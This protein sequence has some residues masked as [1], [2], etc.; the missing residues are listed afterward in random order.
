MSNKLLNKVKSQYNTTSKLLNKV[1]KLS[2]DVVYGKGISDE[3][4]ATQSIRA[5]SNQNLANKLTKNLSLFKT[6]IA[7]KQLNTY[8]LCNP[9][10]F[11]ANKLFPLDSVVGGKLQQIAG[12]IKEIQAAL[13]G[14][15]IIPGTIEVEAISENGQEIKTGNIVLSLKRPSDQP[16]ANG[17]TVFIT[18]I[19]DS[20]I[21]VQMTG[22]V[23]SSLVPLEVNQI[24]EETYDAV[25]NITSFSPLEPPYAVNKNGIVL[26]DEEG[27]P[28]LRKFT[29]FKLEIQKT[30]TSDIRQ[31]AKETREIAELLRSIGI[32][33]FADD[34]ADIQ[35]VPGLSKLAETARKIV[36]IVNTPVAAVSQ[37]NNAI[38]TGQISNRQEAIADFLDGGLTAQQVLDRAKIFSDFARKL[39]PFSNFDFSLDSIF[40]KQ[41]EEI[42]KILNG[43]IPFGDLAKFIKAVANGI[44]F[45]VGIVSFIIL[46]LKVINTILKVLI[47]I[48]KVLIKVIKI[49]RRI[50]KIIGLLTG[51]ALLKLGEKL[52]HIQ[53]ALQAVVDILSKVNRII[54]ALLRPLLLIKK[55]LKEIVIEL[56]KLSVKL[57]S[58]ENLKDSDIT[59]D[60]LDATKLAVITARNLDNTVTADDRDVNILSTLPS[61]S[62]ATGVNFNESE[63]QV[64]RE[65]LPYYNNSKFIDN[66]NG[67]LFNLRENIIGFDQFGNLVFYSPLVSLASGV[68]FDESE[69][70]QFRE[71]L[72]Y[73]TFDKFRNNE[74]VLA[75]LN[76]ADRLSAENIKNAK[77]VDPNDVFGNFQERF[78]GYTI[79]IQEERPL[80]NPSNTQVKTR[81]RGIALDGNEKLVVSTELTFNENLTTIV[82][83]VKFKIKRNIEL[84]LLS[85]NTTDKLGVD[86]SDSD[87]LDMTAGIG[88]PPLIVN[89]IKAEANNRAASNIASKPDPEANIP[90]EARIG[91]EPFEPQEAPPNAPSQTSDKSS[92]AKVSPLDQLVDQGFNDFIQ[93][94]PSLKKIQ[95]TIDL[96]FRA[97]PQQL[98]QILNQP[99]NQELDPEEFAAN[100]KESILDEIDPNPEK[101]QEV[102][103]KTDQWYEGLKEKAKIEYEEFIK[104]KKLKQPKPEFQQFFQDLEEQELPKWIKFLLR[105]RYTETEVESGLEKNEIRDKFKILING[106][107]VKVTIRRAFKRKGGF[108]Q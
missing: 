10:N 43:V 15:S 42:N 93:T 102:K 25:I 30:S 57:E 85:I 98:D 44:R 108:S 101:I 12:V 38:P 32:G 88:A 31:I 75:L 106:N 80:Q 29:N 94:N 72:R 78:M 4:G 19:D 84:G 92:P 53:D 74:I 91:N 73:Y 86:V 54:E 35:V 62:L 6:L 51:G 59:K 45:I 26:K 76:E 41:V 49:V 79:K 69:A 46:L 65:N 105:Q 89:D 37:A 82:Q 3:A 99:G 18:Q 56:T 52:R 90:F 107:D 48:T 21:G 36:D 55:Y 87:A 96:I 81:R 40:K 63:A 16:I 104:T 83:E 1:N 60:I 100:L 20:N 5:Q 33:D 77:E 2:L 13:R 14:F 23:E 7:L 58:C 47:T 66:P 34:I 103:D 71:N 50:L 17:T 61:V 39:E 11:S 97:S 95:D 27:N 68:N 22:T 70:Q 28:I 8:D 9:L 64:F 24:P 67:F